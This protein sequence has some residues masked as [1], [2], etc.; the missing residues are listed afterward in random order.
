MWADSDEVLVASDF[1]NTTEWIRVSD[2]RRDRIGGPCAWPARVPGRNDLLCASTTRT[3]RSCVVPLA[4]DG[5][6]PLSPGACVVLGDSSRAVGMAR[7]ILVGDQLLSMDQ[8]GNLLA[9]RYDAERRTVGPQ[10]VVQRG[11]RRSLFVEMGH[12]GLTRGGDLVFVPGSNGAI[13]EFVAMRPGGA[14]RALP[15]PV[16]EHLNFATSRDGRRI[17]ATAL[18]VSGSM[19]LWIYE[20]ETG[21]GDRVITGGTLG[22]PAWATDGTLAFVFGETQAS[23]GATMLLRPGGAA[24][25]RLQGG[26]ILP[27][28]FAAER[29]LVGNSPTGVND[30]VVAVLDGDRLVPTDTLRLP[31]NQYYPQ[32]SPDGRW[33]TYAGAEKGISQVFVTPFP[34]LDR[35]FKVSTDVASEPVWL[36]DGGLVYRIG[37]CWYQ[38][39]PRAGSIPPFG[40]PVQI[41]CDD[42]FLNTSGLSNTTMP[43]G[44]LLY[45]RTVRPT[46][47][48]Y[49]R[50]IRNWRKAMLE[51]GTGDDG[52]LR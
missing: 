42:R 43:D 23:E 39:R 49:V 32:V 19:E 27:G 16:K 6:V 48:G 11:L 2:G 10:R 14:V 4:E 26:E 13:G 15:I 41:H 22:Y 30:I 1:G 8:A 33:V 51:S 45:L 50:I 40:A 25:G 37:S 29:T 3:R 24:P 18:G 12:F 47:G 31:G 44:S 9:A 7:S 28:D 17:A 38:L 36:S 20:V 52:G 34:S 35:Q 21:Q 5:T 46:T